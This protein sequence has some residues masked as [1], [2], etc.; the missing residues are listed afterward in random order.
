M[1]QP[2]QTVYFTTGPILEEATV[3]SCDGD[4]CI[5]QMPLGPLKIRNA[6]VFTVEE[7]A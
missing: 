6:R 1:L 2:N 7:A 3:L 4:H 5:L